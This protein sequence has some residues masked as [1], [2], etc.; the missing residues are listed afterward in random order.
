MNVHRPT[1]TLLGAQK[2]P[3][4]ETSFIVGAA[5][6]SMIFVF[7]ETSLD[8]KFSKNA[9]AQQ[10][11]GE[12]VRNPSQQK[13]NASTQTTPPTIRESATAKAERLR[14]EQIKQF[15]SYDRN[16]DGMISLDEWLEYK[17]LSPSA[18]YRLNSLEP[19]QREFIQ[20]EKS[21]GKDHPALSRLKTRIEGMETRIEE[22]AKL[23]A[24]SAESQRK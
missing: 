11:Q 19:L 24:E 13:G 15:E 20:L 6:L 16:H 21:L 22:M 12:S 9:V 7:A 23:E 2:L 18:M 8:S 14:F 1:A 10:S 5:I 3:K 4:R 17:S